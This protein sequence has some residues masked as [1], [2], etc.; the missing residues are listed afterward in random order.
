MP[1]DAS[2]LEGKTIKRVEVG[3][4]SMDIYFDDDTCLD[5]TTWGMTDHDGA[6]WSGIE[7]WYRGRQV[8]NNP[9]P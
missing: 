2:E 1:I 9:N 5:I 3:E 4:S 6:N 7:A 8:V